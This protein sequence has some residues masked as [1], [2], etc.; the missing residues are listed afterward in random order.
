MKVFS[1]KVCPRKGQFVYIVAART[2][3]QALS[4]VK[5]HI[6]ASLERLFIRPII[7]ELPLTYEGDYIRIIDFGGYGQEGF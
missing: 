2:P 4:M 5:Y 3:E 6:E 1:V 7:K